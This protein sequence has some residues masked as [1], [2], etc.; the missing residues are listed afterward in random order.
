MPMFLRISRFLRFTAASSCFF[1]LVACLFFSSS[2]SSFF[3]MGT[4]FLL[5]SCLSERY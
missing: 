2:S 1:D 5:N 4:D 3:K